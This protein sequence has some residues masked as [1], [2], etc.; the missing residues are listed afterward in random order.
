MA[1]TDNNLIMLTGTLTQP[2]EYKLNDLGDPIYP[3]YLCKTIYGGAGDGTVLVPHD[4]QNDW[5]EKLIAVENGFEGKTIHDV[6]DRPL[7][8]VYVQ[9][10]RPGNRFLMVAGAAEVYGRGQRMFSYGN[11]RVWGSLAIAKPTIDGSFI[12]TWDENEDAKAIS[13]G[14]YVVV[15]LN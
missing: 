8:R 4:I 15:R 5:A 14:D 13:A 2:Y 10:G 9:Y 1:N 12:G 11:G 7:G 3:G 6:Y